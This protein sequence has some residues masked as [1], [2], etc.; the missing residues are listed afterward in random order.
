MNTSKIEAQGSSW[1]VQWLRICLLVQ[2]TLVRFLVG[3]LRA[4]MPR[5]NEAHV[6]Q[7]ERRVHSGALVPQP[8]E[9]ACS[10]TNALHQGK[11][12]LAM[13]E[14]SQSTMRKTQGSQKK[15]EKNFFNEA[16]C[17]RASML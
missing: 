13:T 5:S 17:L 6:L 1:V 16:Q 8:A 4:Y 11:P 9:P 7:L 3:E 2:G 12:Q 14:E 15:T 10:R